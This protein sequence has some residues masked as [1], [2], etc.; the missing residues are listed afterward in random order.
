M[1]DF[2]EFTFLSSDGHTQLHGA[3]WT[4]ADRKP[5]AVLQIAQAV[6]LRLLGYTQAATCLLEP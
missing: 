2:Q 5:R 3:Q 4:P 6:Y 1:T